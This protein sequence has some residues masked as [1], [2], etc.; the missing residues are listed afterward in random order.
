MCRVRVVVTEPAVLEEARR[1]VE[2]LLDGVD[3]ARCGAGHHLAV[4]PA[5]ATSL[6]GPGYDRAAAW[7]ARRTGSGC[8]V[9]IGDDL[10]VVTAVRCTAS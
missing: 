7:I 5:V 10:A 6:I 2:D 4:D 8:L 9:S 3:R 1:I